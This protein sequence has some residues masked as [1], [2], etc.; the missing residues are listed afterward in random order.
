MSWSPADGRGEVNEG[1]LRQALQT[2]FDAPEKY[3]GT[4]AKKAKSAKKPLRREPLVGRIKR[5]AR[6]AG[7]AMFPRIDKPEESVTFYG[8]VFTEADKEPW[9]ETLKRGV[10]G[11]KNIS[12]A[13]AGEGP[14]PKF[15]DNPWAHIVH[16]AALHVDKKKAEPRQDKPEQSK[17]KASELFGGTKTTG[18]DTQADTPAR[19]ALL[20]VK[21]DTQTSLADRQQRL[22]AVN[23]RAQ[24][25]KTSLRLGGTQP[26][27]SSRPGR[28]GQSPR[29]PSAA[30][31]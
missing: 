28:P 2:A 31:R 15:T 17:P 1:L 9:H 12:R 19:R 18:H 21:Q 13:T 5:A 29:P 30:S 20:R 25:S 27:N 26:G 7:D 4:P 24:A 11:L 22:D 23:R 6:R 10:E 14:T 16:R 3:G 8:R